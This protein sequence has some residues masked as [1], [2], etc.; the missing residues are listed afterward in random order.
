[1]KFKNQT[2][3]DDITLDYNEFIDCDIKNCTVLFYGGKF[4]LIRT[5]FSNVRFGVGGAANDTLAFLRVVRTSS[6]A[7]LDSL[8]D[9]GYQPVPD[10]TTTIN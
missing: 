9:Q 4:A 7:A 5:K 6:Q 3:T 2:F 10:Q 8:L 1:M